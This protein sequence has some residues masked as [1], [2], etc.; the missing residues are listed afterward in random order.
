MSGTN[1][2]TEPEDVGT[3][4]HFDAK[5]SEQSDL[6]KKRQ[7][8]AVR[9]A[10]EEV[11]EQLA[12][13][14]LQAVH[15]IVHDFLVPALSISHHKLS[16]YERQFRER[17]EAYHPG[18]VRWLLHE[19][20]GILSREEYSRALES[21]EAIAAVDGPLPST[22][23]K[24]QPVYE[25]Q[26]L[27][28]IRTLS[29]GH[30]VE[31]EIQ[32]IDKDGDYKSTL[33]AGS[34]GSGKS[35]SMGT[36]TEDRYANGHKIIDLSEM[37]KAENATYD[38]PAQHE[39][40]DVREEMGLDVGFEELAQPD[41]EILVP[42]TRDLN[43]SRIPMDPDGNSVVRP[44]T[45]PA[46]ELTFRQL[47]MQLPHTTDVWEHAILSAYQRLNL[48][49]G[50]WTLAELAEEVRY[51]PKVQERVA[52]RVESA[53]RNVQNK[54][55]IRDK[56]SPYT[57]D[58]ESIMADQETVTSITLFQ[59][60]GKLDKMLLASYLIDSIGD[61][62]DQLKRDGVLQRYPPMSVILREM[63]TVAPRNKSEHDSQRSVEGLMIENLEDFFSLMRH[64][65]ADILAGTQKFYRQLD[66]GVSGHFD[67]F[68]C[69]GGH[70]KDIQKIINTRENPRGDP[71]D[72]ISRYED[73]QCCLVSSKVGYK[74]PIQFAPPRF[75]H[76]DAQEDGDGFSFRANCDATDESLEPVP[77]DVSI[78][79][80]LT[81]DQFDT[82][83]PVEQFCDVA[84]ESTNDRNDH[85]FKDEI[86]VA[87]NK[88]A[89]QRDEMQYDHRQLHGE[90]KRHLGLDSDTDAQLMRS[91]ERTTAHRTIKLRQKFRVPEREIQEWF[92]E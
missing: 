18:V 46:S 10:F 77:W 34:T 41:I 6:I 19:Q 3:V 71:A 12:E 32:A 8:Q 91:G 57:L 65:N 84:I 61:A 21:L 37:N 92:S 28:G 79:E 44:F 1:Q 81:F 33:F 75:H 85:A 11:H 87:Y 26:H 31:K 48:E 60:R 14:N 47:V 24:R 63:H 74:M 76:L 2:I 20:S 22:L 42:M 58:W 80:R 38:I 25:Y 49:G 86:T 56:E 52:D 78:P 50:D 39:L 27:V 88:W 43:E 13:G 9:S 45:V 67:R 69:F 68:Y 62:R 53:L 72:K 15:E 70:K 89:E 59:V 4:S 51:D 90:I 16:A 82:G 7:R 66:P 29:K 54:G 83:S 40:A 55:F 64:A 35:A 36:V 5:Q 23:Q 17:E 73:G 30:N